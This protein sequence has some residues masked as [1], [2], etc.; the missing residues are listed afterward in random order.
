MSE[1]IALFGTSADPPTRAHQRL[2][3]WL[4]QH[5]DRVLA[6][7]SDN[8]FKQH[9]ASLEQRLEMLRRLGHDWPRPPANLGID[10]RL[11]HP[12]TLD[13]LTTA[14]RLWPEA[15]FTVVIGSDLVTQLPRWYRVGDWLGQVD[16][17]VVPRPGYP[18]APTDLQALEQQGARVAIAP[19]EGPAIA[20]SS[21]RRTGDASLLPESVATYIRD[22]GLYGCCAGNR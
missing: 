20:S 13:T 12:R 21:Y 15:R 14:R 2:L 6:W 9:G 4:S 8:P 3:L 16:L 10:P 17:L 11:A 1:R 7:A 19:I 5:Y 22:Q 18:L